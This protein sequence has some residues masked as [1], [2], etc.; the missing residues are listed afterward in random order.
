[1]VYKLIVSKDAHNDANDIAAYITY[2]LSNAQ[3]AS[4][5]LDN[6]EAS[7]RQITDNPFMYA[8]CADTRLRE[9]GYRKVVIK[10][11][12]VIYRVDE[13]KKTAYVIRIVYATRDYAKLL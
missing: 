10:N 5:F 7:Y 9:K 13:A 3:A 12:L 4:R 2:E 11:Y 6:V 8:L 1:M